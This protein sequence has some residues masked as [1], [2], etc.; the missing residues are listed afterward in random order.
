MTRIGARVII[1]QDEVTPADISHAPP[2]RAE[3]AAAR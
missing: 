1:A 2:V 3:A